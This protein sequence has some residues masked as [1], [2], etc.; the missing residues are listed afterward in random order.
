WDSYRRLG[1]HQ[2]EIHG[3][4]GVNFAVWAPNAESVSVI[5]AFNDWDRRKH[6]MRKHVPGG[7]WEL[8]IPELQP[9]TLYKFS[10]KA[11]GGNVVEKCDP[12]G[13][14]AEVPPRTANIVAN[15]DSYEW[16]DAQWMQ[17]RLQRNALDAP[18]SIYE[19]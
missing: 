12:Y 16:G 3:I 6:A 7:I 5:G 13:F 1:A 19:L 18:I 10:V 4:K 15:I 14:A 9:G 2:R 17:N 8:F 11:R